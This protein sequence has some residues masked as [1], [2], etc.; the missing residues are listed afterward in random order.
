MK[1]IVVT[2]GVISGLGKGITASSIGLLMKEAG[3]SVTAIKIDP[4]LNVDAGTMSPYEHG[5][6][7]VLRDGTETDL[8]LGNYERFLGINLSA[9]HN[10]TS[11]KVFQQ[12]IE[13]ERKGK[14]M[15][16]TIQFIPHVTNAIKEM[17]HDVSNADICMVELGGTVGDIE[18]MHFVEALRQIKCENPSDVCVVHV[19]LLLHINQEEKTK[20]TQ[21]CV[22]ELRKLGISPDMLMLRSSNMVS[23]KAKEKIALHCQV[24]NQYIIANTNVRN[25]YEVPILLKDQGIVY[26]LENIMNL[27]HT[28][29]PALESLYAIQNLKEKI[30]IGIVGKYTENSDTYLSIHRSIEHA[31]FSI[32][33][34]AD[35]V[36]LSSEQNNSLS[37]LDGVVIPGGF[38]T[39]GIQGMIDVATYCREKDIP[40]LGICLGMQVMCIASARRGY[41][42]K[43]TS[44][45]VDPDIEFEYQVVICMEELD[46]TRM[47]GTMKLGYRETIITD[48]TKAY[49]IYQS[50]KISE[51]HR[52][53]YEINPFY[54][55]L[56]QKDGLNISGTDE[57]GN[58]FD[59]VEDPSKIFYMGCQFHPEYENK[60][61]DPPLLFTA[62]LNATI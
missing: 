23:E 10:I 58:C 46:Q 6:V 52:H 4:Y 7:Y 31:A 9:K 38:G 48:N 29:T 1:Y 45:E 44:A 50:N 40:L 12:V 47:G 13:D 2:G 21:Q 37:H 55:E 33:R 22:Q 30:K 51:R 61:G 18:S 19:S 25:I 49:E 56:L 53:R 59:I 32:Q 43:C 26:C 14:Y 27:P 8:D 36:Y 41:T 20:P 60:M 62:F 11:G 34:Q 28:K 3:Y 5:E 57:T 24:P 39:R 42:D 17:I 35:I 54:K 15:G 16:Q